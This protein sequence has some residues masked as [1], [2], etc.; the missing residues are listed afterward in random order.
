M[1]A[2]RASKAKSKVI[3][4][5]TDGNHNSGA[6]SPE[7]ALKQAKADGVKIY[8]IG[9]GKKGSFNTA[10]LEK[11]AEESGGNYFFAQNAKDLQAVYDE[12]DSLERSSL[13]SRDYLFKSYWYAF[14]LVLALIFMALYIR[15]RFGGI[16]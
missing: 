14:S 11:V 7:M 9:I 16:K 6:T 3:V 15:S 12:I 10:I 2:L 8:T 5:L 4:L 13:R 1:V